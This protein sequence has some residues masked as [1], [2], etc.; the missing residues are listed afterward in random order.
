MTFWEWLQS[1]KGGVLIA[2]VVGAAVSA[3]MDWNGPVKALR[4]LFVGAACAY[5]L[6]PL[7]IPLVE[8]VL[9]G[10]RANPENAIGA[11]GFVMGMAGIVIVEIIR[12]AFKLR[13]DG[14]KAIVS[15]PA[16]P[17]ANPEA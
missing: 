14:L 10:F 4:A 16:P 3:A 6:H 8:W 12:E 2:G 1:D 11:S 7:A 9:S 17:P 13:R 15:P 5:Y